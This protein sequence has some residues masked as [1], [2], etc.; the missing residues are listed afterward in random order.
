MALPLFVSASN[1]VNLTSVNAVLDTPSN[2]LPGDLMI[3]Y[4][5]FGGGSGVT[6]NTVPTG[7]NTPSGNRVNSTTTVGVAVYWK[8]YVSGDPS[9]FTWVLNSMQTT[10]GIIKAWRVVDPFAPVDV[11]GGQANA[12]STTCTHPSITLLTDNEALDA[13]YAIAAVATFT[14]GSGYTER[15]DA[16]SQCNDDQYV[17]TAGATGTKTVTASAAGPN[18]GFGVGVLPYRGLAVPMMGCG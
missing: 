12:S 10:L 17:L 13:Y 16:N 1:R 9:T 6:I 14:P 11:V 7:W 2:I 18:I 4:V 8:Y 3:A 15:A 5:A